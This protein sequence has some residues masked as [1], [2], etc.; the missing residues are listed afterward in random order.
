MPTFWRFSRR[1]PAMIAAASVL[2]GLAVGMITDRLATVQLRTGIQNQ[3]AA[4]LEAR[5]TALRSVEQALAR[6][7]R[8][9]AED[10]EVLMA[11]PAFVS[12]WTDVRGDAAAQLRRLYIADNPHP[13]G[14]RQRLDIANDPSIYS[15]AHGR[16]HPRFRQ[17]VESYGY[18]DLLLMAPDGRV[19]YSVA[20]TDRFAISLRDGALRDGPL[21]QAFRQTTGTETPETA[22]VDFAATPEGPVA[23]VMMTRLTGRDG[24]LLGVLGLVVPVDPVDSVMRDATG[25]GATGQAYLIGGDR[26]LRSSARLAGRPTILVT[27]F[28]TPEVAAALAGESGVREITAAP[29]GSDAERQ[30]MAA[31]APVDFFGVRYA[32]VAE[33]D[34]DEVLRPVT[35]LRQ[36][37]LIGGVLAVLVVALLGIAAGRRISRP[38]TAMTGAMQRLASGDLDIAIPA[39]ARCDE[40]G[41]MSRA[42]QVFKDNAQKVQRLQAEAEEAERRRVAETRDRQLAISDGLEGELDRAVRRVAAQAGTLRDVAQQMTGATGRVNDESSEIARAAAETNDSVRI[43]ADAANRLSETISGMGRQIDSTSAVA[44][45]AVHEAGQ[46]ER[47]VAGLAE[48]VGRIGEVVQL[49]S[50]IAA[51]TNLLAL[52]ATIEAARAG[53]AGKGFAVVATEVKALA[54][55]TANATKEIAAQIEEIRTATGGAVAAIDKVGTTITDIDRITRD[56][57]DAVSAQQDAARDITDGMR[58]AA[59]S[60]RLLSDRLVTVTGDT[61]ALGGLSFRVGAAADATGELI[62][63]LHRRVGELLRD[64]RQSAGS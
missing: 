38:L 14:Q 9:L 20:K 48:A 49:I 42:V 54:S 12:G 23:G 3:L 7:L 61:E 34:L 13:A 11:L 37:G 16:Y 43:S 46:A 8:R 55:Q 50:K 25:M 41:E 18:L 64:L 21:G 58:Q 17:H 63:A 35:E 29:A 47:T 27:E 59:E 36:G 31:F 30:L 57:L 1:L 33:A 28:D 56:M 5:R 2:T 52:N 10:S 62:E 19:V 53:H 24:R 44:R 45:A 22:F 60:T 51:Q 39:M 15:I 32:M 26:L 6:D 40:I 4:Q